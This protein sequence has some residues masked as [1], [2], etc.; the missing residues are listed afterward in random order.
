MFQKALEHLDAWTCAKNLIRYI[1]HREK[2]SG[3]SKYPKTLAEIS[4]APRPKNPKNV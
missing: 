3:N 2:L 1:T 4:G